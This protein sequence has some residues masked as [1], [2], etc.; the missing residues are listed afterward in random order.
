M[1]DIEEKERALL[2]FHKTLPPEM[3]EE[4]DALQGAQA[5]IESELVALSEEHAHW[6]SLWRL[7]QSQRYGQGMTVGSLIHSEVWNN[8]RHA[9]VLGDDKRRAFKIVVETDEIFREFALESHE[10]T[11]TKRNQSAV[12][13]A[14]NLILRRQSEMSQGQERNSKAV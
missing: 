4:Y 12:E 7:C 2:Q 8:L 6:L 3:Q 5:E 13:G 1:N 10:R 14:Q 11:R 9:G